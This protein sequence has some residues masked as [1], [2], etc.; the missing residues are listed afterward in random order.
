VA[1]E[2][3]EALDLKLRDEGAEPGGV[4]VFDRA[5]EALHELLV[6]GDPSDDL[7]EL[8]GVGQLA[9]RRWAAQLQ[10]EKHT[11]LARQPV[12]HKLAAVEDLELPQ[13]P[14]EAVGVDRPERIHDLPEAVL[15]PSE[16]SDSFGALA[17]VSYHV[18]SVVHL[19]L[20]RVCRT[21]RVNGH[22]TP[23][24]IEEHYERYSKP[25]VIEKKKSPRAAS[26]ASS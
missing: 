5:G 7:G 4:P 20:P 18:S 12:A 26:N 21:I 25:H 16:C 15:A 8:P 10:A 19:L 6:G 2:M 23:T 3:A 9:L 1:E 24:E 22:S 11:L 13:Q 14:P 17:Y